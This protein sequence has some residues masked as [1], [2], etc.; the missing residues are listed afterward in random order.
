MS[1]HIISY[2]IS[3]YHII[4][5]RI[6]SYRTVSYR[7]VSYLII[8][9]HIISYILYHI[10][11]IILY[12]IILYYIILYYIILRVKRVVNIMPCAHFVT[13]DVRHFIAFQFHYSVV[14]FIL[15]WRF[16]FLTVQCHRGWIIQNEVHGRSKFRL[17]RPSTDNRIIHSK[18][19][20]K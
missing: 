11:H 13:C 4:S 16:I 2:H 12:Y 6:V 20:G 9:Y 5:Y 7:T 1:Y 8:S 15:K 3:S 17:N 19:A 10:I 14:V 18:I